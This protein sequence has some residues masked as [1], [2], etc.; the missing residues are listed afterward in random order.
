MTQVLITAAVF[1]IALAGMAIGV[2]ISN[3]RIKGS[4]GGLANFKDRDG[5]SICEACSNPSPECRGERARE[6]AASAN[7]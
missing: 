4:C 6:H 3:R 5:N 1:A 7:D 2:L